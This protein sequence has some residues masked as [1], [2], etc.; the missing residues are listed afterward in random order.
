[1]KRIISAI[2]GSILLV[3]SSFAQAEIQFG[4]GL[5]TGNLSTDGTEKEGTATDTSTR[6]KSFEE[7][8]YGGDLFI[9]NISDSGL[10]IGLSY[11]PL[12]LDIG[13]GKR[14]DSAVATAKGGAENDTGDR[15]ASA[16]VSDLFT[17]YTNVPMGAEGWY[18]LGGVHFATIETTES[19]PN[20]K[21][22]NEDIYGYQIGLG[23]RI[24]NA[25]IELSYSDFEDI[26][27][28]ASG[29][30]KNSVSAEADSVQL[31]VSFGF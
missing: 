11:V 31:R 9:E 29:G 30:N 13:E 18:A 28:T 21:Y 14:T 27:I 4:F 2:T 7:F 19:L 22:G 26:D 24:D 12:D 25:K 20:S 1:M 17:L 16:E 6:S 15:S 5:M 23:R 8:F 10:T 3:W